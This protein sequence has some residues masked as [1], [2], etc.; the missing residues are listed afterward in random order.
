MNRKNLKDTLNFIARARTVWLNPAPEG[1]HKALIARFTNLMIDV[2]NAGL[3]LWDAERIQPPEGMISQP[4]DMKEEEVYLKLNEYLKLP[5]DQ[6][7]QLTPAQCFAA[8]RVM[9]RNTPLTDAFLTDHLGLRFPHIYIGIEE[10][11][12]AHS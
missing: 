7:E 1:E 8:A 6:F 10:D 9:A 5:L 2:E 12:Y 11:G 3:E 4:L